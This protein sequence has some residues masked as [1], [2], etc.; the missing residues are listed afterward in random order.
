MRNLELTDYRLCKIDKKDG[1]KGSARSSE[2]TAEV[3]GTEYTAVL[4]FYRYSYRG[5]ETNVYSSNSSHLVY[6]SYT[7]SDLCLPLPR[8]HR[9]M[10]GALEVLWGGI[11][12][13]LL[14]DR[15]WPSL[16]VPRVVIS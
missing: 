6:G 8:N 9:L 10:L 15:E 1:I 16:G 12:M 14:G 13:S 2:S 11:K 4:K 3:Y 7:L 5:L